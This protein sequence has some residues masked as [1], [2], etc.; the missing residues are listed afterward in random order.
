M[1]WDGP[2]F[3]DLIRLSPAIDACG[4][5]GVHRITD[6][7]ELGAYLASVVRFHFFMISH[8]IT[9]WDGREA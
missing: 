4:G 5:T 1:N 9:S 2:E 7:S 6:A 3:L 8:Q